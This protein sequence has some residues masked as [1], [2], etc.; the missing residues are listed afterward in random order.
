MGVPID[1]LVRAVN[2]IP[3]EQRAAAKPAAGAGGPKPASGAFGAYVIL[4]ALVMAIAATALYVLTS[5][6]I[7]DSKAELARVSAEVEAVNRQAASLQ[8][9]ADFKQLAASRMDTVR[10]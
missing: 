5:N 3:T 9:F 6:T 10:G 2:L 8:A 4:G 7:K 1:A